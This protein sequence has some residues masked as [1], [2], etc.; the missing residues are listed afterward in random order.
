MDALPDWARMMAVVVVMFGLSLLTHREMLE[1]P[2]VETDLQTAAQAEI[3]DPI[4]TDSG[5]PYLFNPDSFSTLVLN[6][7]P[8][9]AV[10]DLT[11]ERRLKIEESLLELGLTETNH[12]Q[13]V[14]TLPVMFQ[15]P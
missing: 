6:P 7:Y 8:D 12:V 2:Q 3:V 15:V 4:P 9:E 10:W 11:P 1:D 13:Q 5:G 14:N